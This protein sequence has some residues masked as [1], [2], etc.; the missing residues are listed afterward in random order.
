MINNI[1]L[2]SLFIIFSAFSFSIMEIAVK[3]S[4][5]NIP[6]MEQVFAR[7]FITLFIS[8]FMMI[9]NKEKKFPNKNNIFLI[10]C[11]SVSGYLGIICYFYAANNMVLADASVLQKTSPFWASFF[12]F[13]LIKE[14]ILKVQWLGMIIAAIGS[15]FII[16]PSFMI[17]SSIISF[18]NIINLNSNIFTALIALSAAMFAG[19]SYSIIGSLKGKESNALIIFY[20]SLFSCIFSLFFIKSFVIP[21]M[22]EILLLLLIGI[23]AGLGQFFLTAAYKKAPVS[24]ISIYNYTGVIFSYIFSIFIFKETV[25]LYSVIGMILTISAA[26]LVYFCKSKN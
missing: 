15:I 5:S 18:S 21:N 17:N 7:N 4:G 19:I 12:A 9:K 10:I 2:G 1:K 26:L 22:T 3:I 14:K 23:F 6:V 11:R 24:S 8:A 16:K 13:I 20:F 25:D